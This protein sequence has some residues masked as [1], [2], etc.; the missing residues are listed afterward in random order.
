MSNAIPSTMRAIQL[1]EPNGRLTVREVPV[2]RPGR[3]QVLVR[4]AA[5]PINP[6][7]LS[8]LTGARQR[9]YPFTPGNEGSGTVVAAGEGLMPRLLL[10]RRVACSASAGG[11]GTWAEY[12]LASAKACIPL[13]RNVSLEQGAMMVVN[14]LS[15]LAILEIA[16]RGR[17]RGIVSTAAASALGAMILRLGKRYGITVI[18]VVRRA[19][20]VETMCGLGAEHVLNSSDADFGEKLRA[21]A[22]DLKATLLL[23]AISG[24]MTG[25]FVEAA[26]YG[27]TIL[28]YA[29]LSHE[30]SVF[31]ARTA[32][33]KNLHLYGWY[34]SN[35]LREKNPIQVLLLMQRVQSLLRTDL[36]S[37]IHQ[38]VPLAAAQ[39]GLEMYM[40]QMSA[41]KVLLVADA[42]AVAPSGA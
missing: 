20:Q 42:G 6:S 25:Q 13:N 16:Q 15:A 19:E 8:W 36:R 18:N 23:D 40:K 37:P 28:L 29:R 38:R 34:L 7:D 14:P 11:S 41:G 33:N 31:N 12:A 4:M 9:I 30:D 21:M 1:E 32:Y 24:S 27:S 10:G 2:P 5:A 26:P 17:H 3:G 35:W 22:G 39:E